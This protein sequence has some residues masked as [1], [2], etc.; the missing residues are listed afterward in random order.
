MRGNVRKFLILSAV[1]IT[2]CAL[3]FA[4][5]SPQNTSNDKRRHLINLGERS[6]IS[7]DENTAKIRKHQKLKLLRTKP[8]KQTQNPPSTNP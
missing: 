4:A 2:F 5:E 1:S 8:K 3:E 6:Q 7:N